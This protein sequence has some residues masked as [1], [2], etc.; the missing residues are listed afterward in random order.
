MFT[1]KVADITTRPRLEQDIVSWQ[2]C[3]ELLSWR[4]NCK[5]IFQVKSDKCP[6]LK[7]GTLSHNSWKIKDFIIICI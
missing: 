4:L 2:Q 5:H 7:S 3:S 6:A 1:N